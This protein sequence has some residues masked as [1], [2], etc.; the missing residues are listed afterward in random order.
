M[1][2]ASVAVSRKCNIKLDFMTMHKDSVHVF[3]LSFITNPPQER[4]INEIAAIV[5]SVYK[6]NVNKVELDVINLHTDLSLKTRENNIDFW[7]L[8]MS[9]Q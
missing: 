6:E 7:N 5:S 1:S 8:V 2:S 9:A 4:V 3:T